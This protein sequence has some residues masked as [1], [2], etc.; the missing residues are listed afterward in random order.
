MST[1]KNKTRSNDVTS[2]RTDTQWWRK[3]F[4]SQ[5]S[6]T[7]RSENNSVKNTKLFQWRRWV[8]VS[9]CCWFFFFVFSLSLLHLSV[10]SGDFGDR[11]FGTNGFSSWSVEEDEEEPSCWRHRTEPG[12]FVFLCRP[13]RRSPFTS[14]RWSGQG[15]GSGPKL[16]FCSAPLW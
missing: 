5:T 6:D 4:I 7:V 10:I 14:R 9:C 12:L 2:E 13:Q 15:R 3:R 8:S 1:S 16:F 11:Y